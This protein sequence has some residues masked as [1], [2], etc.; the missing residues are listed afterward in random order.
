MVAGGRLKKVAGG[1]LLFITPR[2]YGQNVKK[3]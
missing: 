2:C 3:G 1:C